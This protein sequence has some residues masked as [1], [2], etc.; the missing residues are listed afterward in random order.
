MREGLV[1]LIGIFFVLLIIADLILFVMGKV[2]V[3]YNN[4][5]GTLP[6]TASWQSNDFGYNGHLDIAD[7]NGDGNIDIID[8]LMVAQ[9]YVGL[10]ELPP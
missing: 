3:Y 2:N 10:I 7:V 9:A 1:K 8:A 5:D 4:G 6:T